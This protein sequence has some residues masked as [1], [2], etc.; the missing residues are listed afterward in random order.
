MRIS[1]WSSD[2]CSSDLRAW[3][4]GARAAP[5]PRF[6]RPKHCRPIQPSVTLCRLCGRC[7]GGRGSQGLA[8]ERFAE[9]RMAHERVLAPVEDGGTVDHGRR[10]FLTVTPRTEYA[11]VGKAGVRHCYIGW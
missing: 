1:D 8:T 9:C 3:I 5:G 4:S 7:N 2:V 11:R 6:W 10:R